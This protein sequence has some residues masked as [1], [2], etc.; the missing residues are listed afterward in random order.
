MS[1]TVAET[2]T[3]T[4]DLPAVEVPLVS[5]VMVTYGAKAW[6]A[7]AIEA[8]VAHT[9]PV[10]ELIAVDNAS[11]DGTGEW[12]H[13]A[14]RGL[15]LS[16]N[17]RNVGFGPAANQAA[18]AARGRYLF[19]LNSDAMVEPMWL[20]PLL[21]TATSI[22]RVGAVVPAFINLNGTLQEAG[23]VVSRDGGTMSIGYGDDPEKP[24]YRFRRFVHYG[25]G[26]GLLIPRS[27]FLSLG[28]FDARYGIGYCEDV[29]L[30][31]ELGVRRLRTVYEPRSRVR[32][33]RGASSAPRK[34][35]KLRNR[36][37]EVF[38]KH[39][40]VLLERHPLLR[41]LPSFPHRAV[42]ARDLDTVDRILL[43]AERLPVGLDAPTARLAAEISRLCPTSRV[44]AIGLD[45][46]DPAEHLSSLCDKGIELAWGISDWDDWLSRYLFHYS[47][48][49]VVGGSA[50][51]RAEQ[52]LC[53]TQPQAQRVH[54]AT[55]DARSGELDVAPPDVL[56]N[57][58]AIWCESEE[59]CEQIRLVAPGVTCSVVG[60]EA[61]SHGDG[62]PIGLRHALVP[63]GIAPQAKKSLPESERSP[64]T[65]S[66]TELSPRA[67]PDA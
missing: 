28:G 35:L 19:F 56:R 22:P 66:F 47:A 11:P 59:I 67:S 5:I 41:V 45:Q 64:A 63:L 25:S 62:D 33:V 2:E 18:L 26:S 3:A 39:W 34:M 51:V 50:A 8:L 27:I 42:A 30:C 15:V 36:N 16:L 37:V 38:R 40:D 17:N 12:L 14:V 32:H 44:T 7:R 10:Y 20:E 57:A 61:A 21:E 60:Y 46:M 9:P 23:A 58:D 53:S 52:L 55:V 1:S 6:V 13:K 4:I 29:D 24:Q 49:I 31:F 54:Y 43:V 65:Q 48:V